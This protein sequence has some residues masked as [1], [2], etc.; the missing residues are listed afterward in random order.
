MF[1]ASCE[2]VEFKRVAQ[3]VIAL[4]VDSVREHKEKTPKADSNSDIQR[5]F[6][7]S[8]KI[9]KLFIDRMKK[10]QNAFN[11]N[12]RKKV[13]GKKRH[14]LI[15]LLLISN[16]RHKRVQ[17]LSKAAKRKNILRMFAAKQG[18]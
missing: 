8:W 18:L 6:S 12:N 15:A 1:K 11:V 5:A 7:I 17:S 2:N 3:S 13:P 4:F 14:L 10:E 9:V 16:C